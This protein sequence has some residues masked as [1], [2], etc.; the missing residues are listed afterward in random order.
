MPTVLIPGHPVPALVVPTLTGRRFDV[1]Q[2]KPTFLTLVEIYRGQHCPRCHRRLLDLKGVPPRLQERGGEVVAVSTDTEERAASAHAEWDLGDLN[3]GYGLSQATARA[4]GIYLSSPISD[5]E[6]QLMVE[7]ATFWVRPDGTLYAA[8][9]GTAPFV[10]LR[11]ND[12]LEALD[13]VRAR[14]YPP[15]GDLR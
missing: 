3:V 15:R 1:A 2:S 7:P 12:W 14:D 4:W 11:W 5:R 13:V 10:S 6:L 9:Y 8:A